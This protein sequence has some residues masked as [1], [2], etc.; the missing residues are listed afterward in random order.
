MDTQ[1]DFEFLSNIIN[2]MD[3]HPHLYLTPEILKII[4]NINIIIDSKKYFIFF[5]IFV[6]DS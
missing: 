5:I 4:K 1:K 3:K 2:S 6:L